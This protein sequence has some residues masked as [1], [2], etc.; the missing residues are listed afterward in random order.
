MRGGP[1]GAGSGD[2]GPARS[3]SPP[4]GARC[5]AA[6]WP[7]LPLRAR[8]RRAAARRAPRGPIARARSPRSCAARLGARRARPPRRPLAAALGLDAPA[9]STRRSPRSRPEGGVAARALHAGASQPET[10]EWCD[11]RLL[12]RIHRRTLDGLRQRDRAGHAPPTSSASCSRGS[13]SRPGAQLHGRDGLRAVIEQLQGFEAAAGAGRAR[14][15]PRGWPATSRAGST[16]CASRARWRGAGSRRA[17]ARATRA[18][19]RRAAP[20]ALLRRRDLAVAARRRA[21]ARRRP[22]EPAPRRPRRRPRVT[23]WRI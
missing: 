23:C 7:A 8:R 17:R 12:A 20:I 9:T 11:R 4:S 19:P 3:G 2:A 15:C 1:R 5:A 14:S 22:A 21:S 10:I 18:A 6:L 13:T 16:S